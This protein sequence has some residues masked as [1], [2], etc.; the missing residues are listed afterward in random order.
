M[1]SR[2]LYKYAYL[3]NSL[4]SCLLLIPCLP[5]WCQIAKIL[6]STSI[7]HRYLV[8]E[9]FNRYWSMHL[10]SGVLCWPIL[11]WPEWCSP[12]AGYLHVQ[13]LKWWRPHEVISSSDHYSDV[14]MGA[15]VSQSTGVSIVYSNV[16]SDADQRKHQSSASLAFLRGIHRCLWI[17]L[18]RGQWRGKCFHLMTILLTLITKEIIWKYLG[19]RFFMFS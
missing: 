9:M 14:M 18:T 11:W 5:A 10:L 12:A 7:R 19:I 17:P 2:G 1:C 4:P 13:C 16:C 8:C 6:G 3:L 15:M